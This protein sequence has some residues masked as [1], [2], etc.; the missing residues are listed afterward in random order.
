MEKVKLII[1]DD[2]EVVRYGL[3][4]LLQNYDYL[5]VVG[6]AETW[7]ETH[8]LIEAFKPSIVIMDVRLK[9]ECGIECCS[10]IMKRYPNTKVIMLT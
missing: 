8:S 7:Q 6:E 1:V 9:N 4:L 2:H 5:E 3:K 10:E